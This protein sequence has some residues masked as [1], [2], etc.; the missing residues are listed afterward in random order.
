MTNILKKLIFSL[1][2]VFF[3]EKKG[4]YIRKN[5]QQKCAMEQSAR[6]TGKKVCH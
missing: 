4:G 3:F 5:L 2:V 6:N 1:F